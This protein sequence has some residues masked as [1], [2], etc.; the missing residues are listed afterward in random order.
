MPRDFSEPQTPN[1]AQPNP[2]LY[3]NTNQLNC[4][5]CGEN[6]KAFY[7]SLSADYDPEDYA[8]DSDDDGD[9]DEIII[10]PGSFDGG[11]GNGSYFQH[12]MRKD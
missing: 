1:T 7:Y 11:F 8:D 12:A 4:I 2:C 5:G 10:D 9:D 6:R 3:H